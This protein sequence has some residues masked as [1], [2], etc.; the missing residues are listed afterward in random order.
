[1]AHYTAWFRTD[2]SNKRSDRLWILYTF[3]VILDPFRSFLLG[4]T[5]NLSDKYAPLSI[6]IGLKY[7]E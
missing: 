1:V 2:A 5:A 3:S 4:S 6:G 7:F